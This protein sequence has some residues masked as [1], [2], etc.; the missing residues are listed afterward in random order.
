MYKRNRESDKQRGSRVSCEGKREAT[1]FD[2]ETAP[3]FKFRV[4]AR[5]LRLSEA[6]E[7]SAAFLLKFF[8]FIFVLPSLFN[9]LRKGT[10]VLR[11]EHGIHGESKSN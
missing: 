1:T 10:K 5:Q 2:S 6:P 8:F 11:V 3:G 7:A 9:E 4:V